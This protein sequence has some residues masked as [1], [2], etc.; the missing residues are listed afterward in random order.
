MADAAGAAAGSSS[1]RFK[2]SI[3]LPVL[4]PAPPP[5]L[6]SKEELGDLSTRSLG[7]L[8]ALCR[9]YGLAVSG[10]KDQLTA[11]LYREKEP[12]GP[13]PV[14]RPR[15]RTPRCTRPRVRRLAPWVSPSHLAVPAASFAILIC[16]VRRSC[17]RCRPQSSAARARTWCGWR[18]RS[19]SPPGCPP[20]CLRWACQRTAWRSSV[21]A[22]RSRA[23]SCRTRLAKPP[24]VRWPAPSFA[25]APSPATRINRRRTPRQGGDW[26]FRCTRCSIGKTSLPLGLRG[27]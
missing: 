26:Q 5:P 15:C 8:K 23:C 21:A 4:T 20:R 19:S 17:R 27:P 3:P 22:L 10:R 7:E 1:P 9:K 18:C 13:P 24:A 16:S 12:P 25:S 2:L 11:R 14:V 6:P